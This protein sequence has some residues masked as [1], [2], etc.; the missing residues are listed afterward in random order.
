MANKKKE[1]YQIDII[2]PNYNSSKYIVET[3]KSILNQSYKKW[4]LIIVDDFSDEKTLRILKKKFK[5]KNIK[6]YFL[7][8][9][10]G[11]GFCRNYAIAKSNSPYL[12]FIDSDDIWKREK[13][14]K[15]LHFMKK[16]NYSFSYTDYITLETKIE[17]LKIL[18]K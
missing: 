9:N 5:E 1:K 14:E 7:K 18:K 4:K 17:K 2:L 16:N 6:I 10:Q 3:V 8:K 13:L 11:A 12:A 15:Q